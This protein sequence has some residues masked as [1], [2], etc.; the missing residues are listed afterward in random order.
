[1][2]LITL[3][4]IFRIY[5]GKLRDCIFCVPSLRLVCSRQMQLSIKIFD[6]FLG[7]RARANDSAIQCFKCRKKGSPQRSLKISTPLFY[8]I[9]VVL[10]AEF[11]SYDFRSFLVGTYRRYRRFFRS[12]KIV[13]VVGISRL[14][15]IKIQDFRKKNWSASLVLLVENICDPVFTALSV[16]LSTSL[17]TYSEMN[18]YCSSN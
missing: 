14:H 16:I 10:S 1:M 13:W 11:S 12:D 6:F 15:L 3:T 8:S 5:S 2:K 4:S 18:R 7:L 9:R 17:V